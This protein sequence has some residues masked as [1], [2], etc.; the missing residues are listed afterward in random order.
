[1]GRICDFII[2]LLR[3][4]AAILLLCNIPVLVMGLT[5][6]NFYN[7]K[8]YAF[9]AGAAFYLITAFMS[10]A[11]IRSSMQILSH[12][13]THALFAYLTFHRVG[14]IRLNPDDSGGSM[15]LRGHGNWLISLSPYFFP[16]FTFLYMLLM[17]YL[18]G[19]FEG[20]TEKMLI[21]AILGYFAA[22]YWATVLSQ[23][24]SGQTDIINEGFFFSGIIIV[25]GN[26]LVNGIIFAFCSKLWSGVEL[27]FQ[28]L[29]KLNL[30]YFEMLK[31]FLF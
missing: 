19:A 30:Q 11:A 12:E 13:L 22:Y 29:R 7:I 25:G 27:Y 8:F 20:P 15:S 24:H 18:L 9:G 1:M 6:I 21:Y 14:R 3:W 5:H 4:P 17:P 23:V 26:L 16:L 31:N 10:G 28:I 2:N